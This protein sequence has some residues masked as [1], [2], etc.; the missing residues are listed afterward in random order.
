MG[1]ERYMQNTDPRGDY[2]VRDDLSGRHY[3]GGHRGGFGSDNPGGR[4]GDYSSARSYAA[5]GRT[6]WG[7]NDT[8]RNDGRYGHQG[9]TGDYRGS[10][11]SDG[12]RFAETRG[13]D[14]Y[15]RGSGGRPQGYDQDDRGFLAR[16]GDE[17]RSWF[18]D[19][20]AERRRRY[21]EQYGDRQGSSWGG[22]RSTDHDYH[23][24]RSSQISALDRDYDE[25][26][27]ENQQRFHSEFT[28]WRT[29][30][31]GQRSSLDRVTAQ[32]EVIGSDG[33]HVGTVDKVRGDRIILTKNDEAAGGHH[34][35][36]PS[37]WIATVDDKVTIRK[38]AEEAH[39][40]WKDEERNQAMFGDDNASQGGT[41]SYGR[42]FSGSY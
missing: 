27:R 24:W 38:T 13:N 7:R 3:G 39:R 29:E 12:H 37:R 31:Q 33:G 23:S 41:Q 4:D 30:R 36:I 16:A 22:Q 21:D 2:D 5:A 40:H 18:G 11:A 19:E 28:N 34:H 9:G 25:Y 20:E 14:R 26:R 10:Y 32:M 6:N 17:V 8:E 42:S 1:Y 15:G 35:S